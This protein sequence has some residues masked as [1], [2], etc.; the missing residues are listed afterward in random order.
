M[1]SVTLS[2]GEGHTLEMTTHQRK[3]VVQTRPTAQMN[4]KWIHHKSITSIGQ[5]HHKQQNEKMAAP[6]IC[7]HYRITYAGINHCLDMCKIHLLH[8]AHWYPR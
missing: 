7:L 3:A 6:F 5:I 8:T 1:E 4:P 2:Q